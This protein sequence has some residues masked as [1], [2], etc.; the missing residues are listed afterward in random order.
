VHP[1]DRYT[2]DHTSGLSLTAFLRV[3]VRATAASRAAHLCS[4]LV[5]PQI[6]T[7]LTTLFAGHLYQL[8]EREGSACC[9][10]TFGLDNRECTL[11]WERYLDD[12]LF[13]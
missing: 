2:L 5:A 4:T 1:A 3:A 9:L 13:V 6:T 11:G 7:I 10:D 12:D 8:P